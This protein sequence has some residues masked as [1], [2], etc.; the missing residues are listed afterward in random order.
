MNKDKMLDLIKLVA[1]RAADDALSDHSTN[2]FMTIPDE[3]AGDSD[4]V[5]VYESEYFRT[6]DL[7]NKK[8]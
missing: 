5:E 1:A 7:L 8:P 6:A 4:L 2:N 3:I